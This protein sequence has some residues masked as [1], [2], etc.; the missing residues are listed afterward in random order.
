MGSVARQIIAELEAQVARYKKGTGRAWDAKFL[1]IYRRRLKL[2]KYNLQKAGDARAVEL[3]DTEGPWRV[4]VHQSTKRKGMTQVTT[5]NKN[6]VPQG[7]EQ[8]KDMDTALA[9]LSDIHWREP[10]LGAYKVVRQAHPVE[11]APYIGRVIDGEDLQAVAQAV[12]EWS[13]YHGTRADREASIRQRGLL[14]TAG[15]FV[16]RSYDEYEA[17]DIPSLVFA[18]DKRGMAQAVNAIAHHVGE[19]L[20]KDFHSV[21][22]AEIK[23]HGMLVKLK[24]G[25]RYMAHRPEED[26]NYYG[27][28]PGTVEP[29]DWYSGE[30]VPPD[31][32]IKGSTM[33]R[34][35]SRHGVWPR[36]WGPDARKNLE[37]L[38]I[39]KAV[40]KRAP[41]SLADIRRQVRAAST[42]QLDAYMRR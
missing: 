24:D 39:K 1:K 19:K 12:F 35:L 38:A 23:R 26:E 28:H 8:V 22:D 11:A 36:S 9:L 25:Q 5:F 14:P 4:I 10:P 42:A 13:L 2:Y 18:A 29:G 34:V 31:Q 15:G 7:D 30:D 16:S 3:K 41:F 40:K 6:M 32:I 33:L 21:T 20:N 27:Q 37:Q 17:G